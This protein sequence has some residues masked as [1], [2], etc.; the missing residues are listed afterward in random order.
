MSLG[1]HCIQTCPTFCALH[2]Q[3]A[4]VCTEPSTAAAIKV[5]ATAWTVA[6]CQME[7]MAGSRQVYQF[8]HLG[9]MYIICQASNLAPP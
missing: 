9:E 3:I 8:D 6:V 1:F 2:N 4:S 5:A 7:Q